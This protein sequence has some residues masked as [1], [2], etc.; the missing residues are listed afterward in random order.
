MKESWGR[1]VRETR[2]D[3]VCRPETGMLGGMGEGRDRRGGGEGG[4]AGEELVEQEEGGVGEVCGAV[5][6]LLVQLAESARGS[7]ADREA[8][9]QVGG[10]QRAGGEHCGHA[11]G[12]LQVRRG[13]DQV[14]VR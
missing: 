6:P 4:E 10:L 9:A 11:V 12:E 5:L 8:H 14:G 3:R 7:G 13:D 1:R 2:R